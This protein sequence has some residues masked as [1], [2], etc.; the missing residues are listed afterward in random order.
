MNLLIVE[1]ERITREG[2]LKSLDWPDLGIN[3]V[4]SA[5]NGEIGLSMAK[6][7]MPD[8]VLTD[9]RMPRMDGITMASLIR[10]L[11]PECRI[12]FLSAYSEI[13]YYKAAI[14]LRA[15]QYL[16]KPI[17]SVRLKAVITEAVMECK[18]LSLYKTNHDL[19]NTQKT[20]KLADAL[21]MGE[22]E[23][24]IEKK[25]REIN[26]PLNFKLKDYCVAIVISLRFIK[27][28]EDKDNLMNLASVLRG[29]VTYPNI[30][31]IRQE[32]RIALFLFV[33][34]EISSN[35][36]SITCVKLQEELAGHAY[37]IAA[38][39]TLRGIKNANKSYLAAKTVLEKAYLYTW[40]QTLFYSEDE[41]KTVDINAYD[42]EKNE[43]TRYLTGPYEKEALDSCETLYEKLK[44]RKDLPYSKARELY[45][46]LISAV[47]NKAESLFLRLRENEEE[48][49]I[50]WIV[51]IE[52]FNLDELHGFLHRQIMLL[53][54]AIEESRNEKKQILAIKDYIVKNYTD[55]TFSIGDIGA[56]LHMSISHVC[57]MFKK[58][59]GDTIN[60]YLT[61]YRLNKAKQYLKETLFTAAEISVKV[62]YK[63]S[64]YFG[65]IFRKRFGIT[66]NEYR[67]S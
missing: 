43:I 26:P 40:G 42:E 37:T 59:T 17:D 11:L 23:D 35:Q 5:E 67:N 13:D 53:F 24:E 44:D 20:Q 4:F 3:K 14:G 62:G 58:E 2:L 30:Y 12:I 64:S 56:F 41:E 33:P 32:H 47:F 22:D 46:E 7:I 16:D 52:K 15:I 51:R 19:R 57:T 25:F 50:S 31:T 55:D 27:E 60:N 18:Q 45:F 28:D 10:E 54:A 6:R 29:A 38:G 49:M 66:P 48:E 9:I 36:I 39:K 1:D 61:E 65:R 8:I 34:F 63:D 21:C